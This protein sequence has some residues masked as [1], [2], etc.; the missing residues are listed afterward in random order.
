MS[1]GDKELKGRTQREI[2]VD[3]AVHKHLKTTTPT[4]AKLKQTE[5]G[6]DDIMVIRKG[7]SIMWKGN[8]S[9]YLASLDRIQREFSTNT[10]RG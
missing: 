3:K 2:E 4:S 1:I 5:H 8:M 7:R 6:Q 10:H 9:E